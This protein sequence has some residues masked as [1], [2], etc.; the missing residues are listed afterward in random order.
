LLYNVAAALVLA[1]K[2]TSAEEGVR[3][4]AE[5]LDSGAARDRLAQWVQISVA[6]TS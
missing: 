3:L 2:A 4:G 6:V 5:A 1:E